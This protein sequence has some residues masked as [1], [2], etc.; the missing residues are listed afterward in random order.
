LIGDQ[1][2]SG[3]SVETEELRAYFGGAPRIAA[4]MHALRRAASDADEDVLTVHA[5]DGIT[6]TLYYTLLGTDPDAAVINALQFDAFVPGNHEF[7]D[8]DANL[9]EFIQKLTVP[10][11]S[12]NCKWMYLCTTL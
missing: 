6:G 11:T 2:P 9:A 1:I 3:L 5:G 7:D 4:T 12:H 10:V 8:G